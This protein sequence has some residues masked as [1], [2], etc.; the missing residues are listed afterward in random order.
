MREEKTEN[1]LY[2]IGC[3]FVCFS[4][5]EFIVFPRICR[6]FYDNNFFW[7]FSFSDQ[8]ASNHVL[9]ALWSLENCINFA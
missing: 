2:A 5:I 1:L 6:F 8:S 7:F 4:E 9:L 3:A